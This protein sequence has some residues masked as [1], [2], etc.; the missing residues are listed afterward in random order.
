MVSNSK[1][2]ES[3]NEELDITLINIRHITEPLVDN[4]IVWYGSLSTLEDQLNTN[5]VINF[6]KFYKYMVL[7][8][9]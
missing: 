3:W 5:K 2:H 4:N 6:A 9:V 7:T 1:N 8:L